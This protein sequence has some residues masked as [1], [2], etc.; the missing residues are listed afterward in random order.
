MIEQNIQEL[1]AQMRGQVLCRGDDEYDAT[2]R[3]WNG[4][5]DKKPLLI[6]RCSGLADVIDAVN[7]GRENK[8]DIAI[9]GGGHNVAGNAVCDDGLMID[10]SMMNGV[11]VDAEARTAW[12]QGGAKL[13]D[14]DRETQLYG[15]AAPAGVVSHTGVAGLTLG[16]GTGWLSGKYGL[17]VDNLLSVE[18][19]SA[20]GRIVK[21][22]QNE[23]PDLFWGL[24]GGGGNFGVATAFEF[25]LHP[26]G[27]NI[28]RAAVMY[29]AESAPEILRKWRALLP[30]L[31]DEVTSLAILW[32]IPDV[33]DFPEELRG[34]R[35]VVVFGVYS[36]DV[37]EGEKIVQPLRE[38]GSPLLDM[39]GVLPF[40]E[41]QK[42][43]DPFVPM[44]ELQYYWKSLELDTIDDKVIEDIISNADSRPTKTLIVI[45]AMKGAYSRVATEATAYGDRSLPY[46]LEI[47]AIW[48]NPEDNVNNIA[49]TRN[50][51]GKMKIH[52]SSGGVYLNHPGFG[53]EG[54][55]LVKAAYGKNY[56]RLVELKNK[57]DPNNLFHMNQNIVPT[58]S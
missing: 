12:V 14:L 2:R 1:K 22:S 40:T 25:Q 44:H 6:A 13:G 20:D 39:S 24:Q 18:L 32:C 57:Y 30:S 7:F 9:R 11:R 19:V 26:V 58:A 54:E 33:D 27:P 17:T 21:A 55:E 50:F 15:L 49:W 10:L 5:I 48:D 43:F 4:M 3:I 53:E 56:Q 38:L 28:V 23:N 29:P 37:D 42:T 31:P 35:V 36:D 41:Q 16:G 8:L 45:Q 51:W 52:S 34:Q 47:N 46:L